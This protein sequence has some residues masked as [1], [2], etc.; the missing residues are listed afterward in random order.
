MKLYK[1]LAI[2]GLLAVVAVGLIA[3]APVLLAERAPAVRHDM[4]FTAPGGEAFG[5][6]VFQFSPQTATSDGGIL[7]VEYGNPY[8]FVSGGSSGLLGFNKVHKFDKDGN[9][10]ESWMQP[11]QTDQW[12]YRDLAWD[13]E[14]LYGSAG[15]EIDKFDHHGNVV[16]TFTGPLEVHRALAY[17]PDTG[18]LWTANWS[19]NI[20]EIDMEG[21]VIH[22]YANDKSI[23]G[24]AWD[25]KS[26]DGPWL[27]VYAQTPNYIYQFNPSTGAYTAV[28]I[29]DTWSG[30]EGLAAGLC[31]TS[32][33]TESDNTGIL[34]LVSQQDPDQVIGLEI[35]TEVPADDDLVDDDTIDDDDD[36]AD[37][38]TDDDDTDDDD[39]DDDD[40]ADDDTADDDTADDDTVDDDTDDDDIDEDDDDDDDDDATPAGDDDDDNDDD[41]DGCGC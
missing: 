40:T 10:L 28:S 38:D 30:E 34:F 17:D 32:S 36:T 8:F 23:Y 11:N 13:G 16:D 21:N 26:A 7:G 4:H 18:H 2:I 3:A 5:D 12:G 6:I 27:W 14:Y 9:Y 15:T 22:Q 20:Y 35:V 41:D 37:D 29:E 19:S 31:F 24:M 25:D 1:N 39:T 33:W